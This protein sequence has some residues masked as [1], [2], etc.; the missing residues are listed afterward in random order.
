[1]TEL[2]VGGI[3]GWLGVIDLAPGGNGSPLAVPVATLERGGTTLA[4]APRILSQLGCR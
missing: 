4:R 3:A 2:T 1:M